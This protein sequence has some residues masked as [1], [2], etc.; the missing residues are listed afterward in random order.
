[1]VSS[2]N[3]GWGGPTPICGLA[4]VSCPCSQSSGPRCPTSGCGGG[5]DQFPSQPATRSAVLPITRS[6][7]V[8]GGTPK[9]NS[10]CLV[11][12]LLVLLWM[13]CVLDQE[14]GGKRMCRTFA[15]KTVSSKAV[16]P[17]TLLHI[18]SP[19]PPDPNLNTFT[20]NTTTRKTKHIELN[21]GDKKVP[22]L[23]VFLGGA[24]HVEFV[25]ANAWSW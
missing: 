20:I 15:G 13:Y 21:F 23:F 17:A 25:I 11:F 4:I 18:L 6:E 22:C 2:L 9:F 1:M 14:G 12:W 10:M 24:L 3:W 8:N 5:G 16:F 19:R 7:Q